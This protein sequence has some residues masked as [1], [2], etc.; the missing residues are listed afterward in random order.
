MKRD[1]PP[2][3]LMEFSIVGKTEQ[4]KEEIKST[5]ER[6]GGKLGTKI[7][8]KLTAVISNKKEVEKMNQRM[9]DAKQYGIQVVTEDFFKMITGSDALKL[10]KT[11]SICDWGTDVRFLFCISYKIWQQ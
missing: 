2:L 4:P 10:I 7:H 11:Q 3:Y 6:L 1:K 5:I 8:K 9:E